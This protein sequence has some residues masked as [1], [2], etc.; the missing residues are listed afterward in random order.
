MKRQ[1]QL[2]A[3]F[4]LTGCLF[5]VACDSGEK[6]TEETSQSKQETPKDQ[7]EAHGTEVK[8]GDVELTNPL[9]Q[10]WVTSGKTIYDLK[11][12]SCHNLTEERKVGP[13]WKDITKRREIR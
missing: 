9:N 5:F 3:A 6:T 11:C 2:F 13:G 7:P 12:Q 4:I 10:Q 1:S 8:P